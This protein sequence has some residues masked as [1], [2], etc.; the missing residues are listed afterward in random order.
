MSHLRLY[1]IFTCQ[2]CIKAIKEAT[3]IRMNQ[4]YIVS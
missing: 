4:Y 3:I 1:E 2:L